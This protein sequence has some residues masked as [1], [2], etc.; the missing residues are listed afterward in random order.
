MGAFSDL[1]KGILQK[2]E[3]WAK[4]RVIPNFDPSV[5]RWDS[6]G[7]VMRY[8]DYGQTPEYGW[9]IDHI[10]PDGSDELWNLQPLNWLN[11]RRKSDKSAPDFL[12]DLL[13]LTRTRR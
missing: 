5:W 9:E 12:N 10:D 4:G 3:V 1:L 8:S 13:G 2:D 7:S 6:Y 11:N